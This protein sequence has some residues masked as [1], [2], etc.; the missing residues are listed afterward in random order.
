METGCYRVGVLLT[1]ECLEFVTLGCYTGGSF[2]RTKLLIYNNLVYDSRNPD[3][4]H[5]FLKISQFE[6]SGESKIVRLVLA[7]LLVHKLNQMPP[8]I[9]AAI[10]VQMI[11]I[12][13]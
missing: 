10:L 6:Q 11:D 13:I 1:Q 7:F 3:W 12:Q 4:V 2:K 9:K 8:E 5:H